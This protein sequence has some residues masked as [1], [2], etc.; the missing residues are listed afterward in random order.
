[1]S[2]R[3]IRVMLVDDHRVV[4]SGLSA[5]LNLYPDLEPVGEASNGERAISKCTQLKPDVILMD[6]KM[7]QMDGIEATRVIRQQHPNIQII[8]LTS[9]SEN[10]LVQ[11][12]LQAGAIG[13]LLKNV[14]ADELAQAIKN[15][16]AGRPT[17]APEATQALIQATTAGD[18]KPLG[19]DLTEREREVLALVVEGLNNTQIAEKLIISRSTTKFHVSNILSKLQSTSRTE[20]AAIA[21]QHGLIE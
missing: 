2:D 17:L 1:M 19:H 12:I 16:H 4:R 10:E 5:F 20:A 15:A 18:A 21:V 6:I 9:F 7:P 13:Y 8:A 3:P 11:E 14:E